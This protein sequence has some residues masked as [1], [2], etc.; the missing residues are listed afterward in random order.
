MRNTGYKY[1]GTKSKY[2]GYGLGVQCT[3]Y[4]IRMK[5]PC[6]ADG[7]MWGN[8]FWVKSDGKGFTSETKSFATNSGA[9]RDGNT[10]FFREPF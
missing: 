5:D 4:G 3:G 2:R 10:N 8:T 1:K 7:F 9:Y 6:L